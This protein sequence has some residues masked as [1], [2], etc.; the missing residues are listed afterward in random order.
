MAFFQGAIIA[1]IDNTLYDWPSF[2]APSFRAMVHALVRETGIEFEELERQFKHVYAQHDSLEFAFPIQELE[3][4]Q[5]LAEDQL[6][7]LIFVGRG[8][9]LSAY[10][11]HLKPYEGVL[12]GLT[13]LQS[14]D[15]MTIC[16]TNSPI[17]LAQ[18][19]LYQ[20]GLDKLIEGLIAWE[21]IGAESASYVSKQW[22]QRRKTRK[23][24]RI[25]QTLTFE[26]EHSKPSII[27]FE[28][29]IREF[30]LEPRTT[31][32]IGD[33]INKDLRPA[34]H[35]GVGTIWAEYGAQFN[36]EDKNSKTLLRITNWSDEEIRITHDRANF[37]PD[38]QVKKFSDIIDLLPKVQGTLF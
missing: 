19:R 7:R 5:G 36:P 2:F 9:F 3:L 23:A 6:D 28:M 22:V 1:D 12:E 8:A 32:A 24:T 10:R 14:Q 15:Y 21:G 13:W 4:A 37:L 38:H 34:S 26:R 35:L 27:P 20:L 18:K 25:S 31:W 11:K 30:S 33:S 16:V 17:Y 29:A